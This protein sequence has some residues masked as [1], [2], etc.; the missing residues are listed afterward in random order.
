MP[1][2]D[3]LSNINHQKQGGKVRVSNHSFWR[4][5]TLTLTG[6]SLLAACALLPSGLGAQEAGFYAVPSVSVSTVYDDNILFD[7][8]GLERDDLITRV[9]PG[10]ELGYETAILHVLGSYSFDSEWYDDHSHLDSYHVRRFADTSIEY[11]P[12]AQLA[13]NL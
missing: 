5:K 10:L 1:M 11:L 3:G 13:L 4:P 7:R 12:S 6:G 8:K 2:F 9:S